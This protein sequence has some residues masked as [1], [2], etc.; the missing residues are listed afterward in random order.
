MI[1]WGTK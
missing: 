1:C